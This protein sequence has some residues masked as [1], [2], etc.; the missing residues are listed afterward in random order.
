MRPARRV[1]AHQGTAVPFSLGE[2]ENKAYRL[3]AGSAGF[4]PPASVRAAC[5]RMPVNPM[6]FLQAMNTTAAAI[7]IQDRSRRHG[8]TVE[9]L[10]MFRRY[11]PRRRA[12][13]GRWSGPRR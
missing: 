11:A 3:P 4:R 7:G 13:Q 10:V 8:R 1:A 6:E 9:H 12:C 2:K 5:R